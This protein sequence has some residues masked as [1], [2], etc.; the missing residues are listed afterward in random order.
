MA[1]AG[2]IEAIG[3]ISGVLGIIQFGV[4]NF[5]E[6]KTVG[7][8]IRLTVGLDTNGG[9]NN[10]GGDLPDVRL[11][12]EAGEFI[13]IKAGPGKVKDG[14]FGDITVD[15]NDDTTQQPTYALF[16]ANND[17]ICVAYTSI[18][19]PNGDKYTWVGNW[20]HQCG[21]SW[22]Y[23]N[24]YISG[25]NEKP[26]CLWIDGNND[27]PQSGFQVHWPEFVQKDGDTPISD[28]DQA[29]KVDRLCNAGPPF[30]MY[31]YADVK[32]PKGIT[33]WTINNKRDDE[34]AAEGTA[35]SY[36]PPTYPA[37]A[38]FRRGSSSSHYPRS[39]GTDTSSGN[40]SNPHFNR[41]IMSN[42]AQHTA[43]G[44]CESETSLGPDFLNVA[45]GTFCR[46]SD[47][48]LWPV[49]DAGA[50][51]VDNCFSMDVHQLVVNG[52]TTRDTPYEYVDDW[53]S[54]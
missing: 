21:G 20:G 33:F 44:L 42:A 32:D 14:G 54:F 28:V 7:S 13:G 51:V 52:L 16:S 47:K 5:A 30:K 24:V 45:D 34:D 50:Q 8:T 31:Q 35:V 49:C 10:A 38:K 53:T 12:N 9:L 22:Y 29:A 39:N 17:A 2:I 40:S 19:W 11:F 48:T 18:T 3:V 26:D 15:H 36:G 23:S 41:L 46:M 25:S 43:A 1:A 4:D 37:S 6:P 27:Q